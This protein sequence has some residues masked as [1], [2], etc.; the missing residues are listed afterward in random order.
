M[1]KHLTEQEMMAHRRVAKTLVSDLKDWR[2][3][4][5]RTAEECAS[6]ATKRIR[7]AV[8]LH[9]ADPLW[10]KSMMIRIQDGRV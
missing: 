4:T 1:M 3:L 9:G 6:E 8:R 5:P 2:T 7:E 10:L